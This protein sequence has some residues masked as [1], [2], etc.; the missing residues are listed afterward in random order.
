MNLKRTLISLAIFG[1]VMFGL[2]GYSGF[3]R[4]RARDQCL[5]RLGNVNKALVLYRA[6][7]DG[8]S[9]EYDRADIALGVCKLDGYGG[10]KQL[11]CPF[12]LKP[13]ILESRIAASPSSKASISRRAFGLYIPFGTEDN[14]VVASCENHVGHKSRFEL[15][16]SHPRTVEQD[17]STSGRFN[18]LLRNGTAKSIPFSTIR[19][20]WICRDG[21]F[22]RIE[23]RPNSWTGFGNVH[24]FDFEPKPPRF[25]Y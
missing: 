8:F 25:E 16:N 9:P 18:V 11:N 14:S 17:P 24:I 23:D 10:G 1:C 3:R 22:K 13:L 5:E 15:P 12:E 20:H 21:E 7:F 2:V 4:D 19:E 6:D